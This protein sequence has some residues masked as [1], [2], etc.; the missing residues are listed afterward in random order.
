[1][2]MLIKLGGITL[3]S[4]GFGMVMSLFFN[5]NDTSSTNFV[6]VSKSTKSQLK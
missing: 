6:D 1:M 2:N 4:G 3:V 5:F